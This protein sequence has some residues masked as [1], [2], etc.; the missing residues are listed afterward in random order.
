M[1]EP[2]TLCCAGPSCGM[3]Y[4]VAPCCGMLCCAGVFAE[5]GMKDY[6]QYVRGGSSY[7]SRFIESTFEWR[8]D[9]ADGMEVSIYQPDA[10]AQGQ[11]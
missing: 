3:L 2:L 7:S 6:L 4:C 8:E 9:V 11:Q 10:A 5:G 1:L